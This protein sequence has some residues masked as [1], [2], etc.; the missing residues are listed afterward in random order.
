MGRR[1]ND[2][3]VEIVRGQ[4]PD[5]TFSWEGTGEKEAEIRWT[6]EAQV[7][8]AGRYR[9]RVVEDEWKFERA[10]LAKWAGFKTYMTISPSGVTLE[11]DQS[12]ESLLAL[13][14]REVQELNALVALV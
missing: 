10:T 11:Q 4:A 5:D 14:L 2:E 13:L 3:P 7:D 8:P 1:V 12:I 6:G 9:I